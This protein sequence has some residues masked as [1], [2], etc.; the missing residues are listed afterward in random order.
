MLTHKDDCYIF[1]LASEIKHVDICLIYSVI[2]KT[3]IKAGF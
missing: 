3:K 1:A 2:I